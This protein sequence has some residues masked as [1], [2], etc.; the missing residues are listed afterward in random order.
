MTTTGNRRDPQ[1]TATLPNRVWHPSAAWLIALAGLV[2]VTLLM[3][4]SRALAATKTVSGPQR[5]PEIAATPPMVESVWVDRI[6]ADLSHW[7]VG[8]ELLLS[9]ERQAILGLVRT[10]RRSASDRWCTVLADAIYHESMVAGIDPLLVASIVATESSFKSRIVSHAGAVG[11]MQLRPWVARDLARRQR[12]RWAG[13]ETLNSPRLN[14]RLGI[15]YYQELVERFD[16]DK[17]VALTAYNYGPTRVSRQI[18]RGT[19]S[20]SRYASGIIHLYDRLDTAR[21]GLARETVS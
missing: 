21:R 20:G 17:H 1:R 11:L 2:L 19:Y 4:Q 3:V 5:L 13:T 16:G 14:V 6:W 7:P 10:H 15:L 18:A 12:I 8:S 9:R